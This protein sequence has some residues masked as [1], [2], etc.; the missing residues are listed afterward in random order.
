MRSSLATFVRIMA[1]LVGMAN[2]VAYLFVGSSEALIGD[3]A[4]ELP[5]WP[6]ILLLVFFSAAV[7]LVVAEVLLRLLRPALEGNFLRRYTATVLSYCIGGTL[8]V[9][10]LT[11][12]IILYATLTSQDAFSVSTTL[13]L[14][15]SFAVYVGLL[16]LV[17]G[18]VLGLP[19]A[20]LLG[21]FRDET[22][23]R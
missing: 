21:M 18:L 11:V 23:A 2:L 10:L 16:S 13:L 22:G 15:A 6:Y 4:G 17:E 14:G 5:A 3:D 9:V 8:S 7:G 20:G 1:V 12:T 19:L